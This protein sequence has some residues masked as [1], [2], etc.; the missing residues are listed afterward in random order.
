MNNNEPSQLQSFALQRNS[1]T[2]QA[3]MFIGSVYEFI[4]LAS[5]L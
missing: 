4:S 5:G 3:E 2:S 1:S